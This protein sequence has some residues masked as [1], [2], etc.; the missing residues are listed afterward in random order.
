M[1]DAGIEGS[2]CDMPCSSPAAGH[3]AEGLLHARCRHPTNASADSHPPVSGWLLGTMP[4]MPGGSSRPPTCGVSPVDSSG[5][6]PDSTPAATTEGVGAGGGTAGGS[7]AA[8][9]AA[10]PRCCAGAPPARAMDS[11]RAAPLPLEAGSALDPSCSSLTAGGRR[12]G[13]AGHWL[14]VSFR[15][16]QRWHKGGTSRHAGSRAPERQ[17]AQK[18]A[19]GCTPPSNIMP[20]THG[21]R[22]LGAARWGRLQ[23]GGRSCRLHANSQ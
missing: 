2:H 21:S 4:S 6:P 17:Q 19:A 14:H 16:T 18:P 12:S 9:A 8:P 5:P 11:M 3:Y 13:A 10:V 20:L 23:H 7:E 22:W 1:G 15:G